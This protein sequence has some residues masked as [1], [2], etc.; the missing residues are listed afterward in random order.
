[1]LTKTNIVDKIETLENG[2]VQVRTAI[3]IMEDG[4]ILSQSFH[5][6]VVAP[7]QD[8]SGEDERVQAICAAVHTPEVIAAYE[9]AQ[10][11]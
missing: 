2:C 8:Y 10:G 5:R 9:A 6:H 11:A 3:R 4:N 1:M 7:G